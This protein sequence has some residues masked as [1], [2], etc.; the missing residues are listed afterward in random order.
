MHQ[1]INQLL[2]AEEKLQQLE[3]KVGSFKNMSRENIWK[4]LEPEVIM[5]LS[6]VISFCK[7]L[8]NSKF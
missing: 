3:R 2:S 1:L 4:T 8:E 7:Y 6:T 5:F